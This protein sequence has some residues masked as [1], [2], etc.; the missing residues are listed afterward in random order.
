MWCVFYVGFLVSSASMCLYHLPTDYHSILA[1]LQSP[2]QLHS[3]PPF[4]ELHSEPP[5]LT[6]DP[7]PVQLHPHPPT[8][9]LT[10]SEPWNDHMEPS[11]DPDTSTR[12]TLRP[13]E[14]SLSIHT[15]HLD[16]TAAT[17]TGMAEGDQVLM[18]QVEE[19]KKEV[20]IS[21]QHQEDSRQTG[22]SAV[23]AEGEAEEEAEE[24]VKGEIGR[25]HV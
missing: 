14:L 3:D 18:V 24:V 8:L 13:W 2:V 23:V 6:I 4:T 20:D 19:E 25:A 10:Q 12:T 11:V 1:E 7:T 16:P 9:I 15:L 5:T 21:L 22:A 17:N